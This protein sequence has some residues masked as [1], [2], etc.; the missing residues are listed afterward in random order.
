M[1][2]K[3]DHVAK[4]KEKGLKKG[5]IF[6]SGKFS[7]KLDK[8]ADFAIINLAKSPTPTFG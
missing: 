1:E 5:T 4:M 3:I 2:I 6:S 7:E 8:Y